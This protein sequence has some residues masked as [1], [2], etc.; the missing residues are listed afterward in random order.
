MDLKS[1]DEFC[2]NA[3]KARVRKSA[4]FKCCVCVNP[5]MTSPISLAGP[6]DADRERTRWLIEALKPHGCYESESELDH[7]MGVLAK[8]NKLVKDWIRDLSLEKNMCQLLRYL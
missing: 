1:A 2:E 7:R 3:K 5:G 8:L 6:D 4:K